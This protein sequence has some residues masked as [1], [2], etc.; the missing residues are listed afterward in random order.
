MTK[1]IETTNKS[2][3][4]KLE[5]LDSVLKIVDKKILLVAPNKDIDDALIHGGIQAVLT[6]K[7]GFNLNDFFLVTKWVSLK[8]QK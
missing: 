2:E 4:E 3:K 6:A 8:I 7:F 1:V 5:Y